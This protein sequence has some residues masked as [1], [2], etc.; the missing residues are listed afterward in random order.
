MTGDTLS[1][2]EVAALDAL[3]SGVGGLVF[4]A[5]VFVVAIQYKPDNRPLT[6]EQ[7]SH[8]AGFLAAYMAVFVPVVHVSLG[9]LFDA[10]RLSESPPVLLR[11]L[12]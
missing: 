8:V 1:R 4:A 5:L 12:F 11:W 2:R 3:V 9:H 7:Y 10:R 6:V